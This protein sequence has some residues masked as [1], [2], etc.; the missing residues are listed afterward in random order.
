MYFYVMESSE[1]KIGNIFKTGLKITFESNTVAILKVVC[2]KTVN[3]VR[4]IL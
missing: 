1:K 4:V 2:I 3:A